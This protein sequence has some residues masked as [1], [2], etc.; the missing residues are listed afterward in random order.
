MR[1]FFAGV[2]EKMLFLRERV[3][4]AACSPFAE[5]FAS[6]YDG[7]EESPTP[8]PLSKMDNA[9]LFPTHSGGSLHYRFIASEKQASSQIDGEAPKRNDPNIKKLPS[10]AALF[11]TSSIR[12]YFSGGVAFGCATGARCEMTVVKACGI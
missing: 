12:T 6:P 1:V 4:G 8:P 11:L 9:N 2:V 3:D 5:E 10:E 7:P